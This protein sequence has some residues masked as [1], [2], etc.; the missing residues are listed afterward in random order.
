MS[1][2]LQRLEAALRESLGRAL[3]I[4]ADTRPLETIAQA[5][6]DELGGAGSFLPPKDRMRESIN[7]FRATRRLS[8]VREA[9]LV[10]FG[11]IERFS[12]SP[13]PLI[14]EEKWFLHMLAEVDDFHGDPRAFRDCYRGLLRAYWSY[15][16]ESGTA[17]AHGSVSHR[18]LRNYLKERLESV[19]VQG[20]Q[21]KWVD[22]ISEH[23][24][25]LTEDPVDR[26][27]RA[28]LE[29]DSREFDQAREGLEIHGKSWILRHLVLAQ[30]KAATRMSD[31][32]FLRYVGPLIK[33]LD[34]Y[35]LQKHEGLV[36][37]LDRYAGMQSRPESALLRDATIDAWGSP[38]MKNKD[39][40]WQ[41]VK[42][43]SRAMVLG[44]LNLKLIQQFF[45][46]LAEDRSTDQRRVRF[47]EKYHAQVEEIYFALGPS[48]AN[49]RATD[50][51]DLRKEM[52]SHL[53]WLRGGGAANNAFIMRMGGYVIVEFGLTGN[54]CYIFRGNDLPFR[55]SGEVAADR[56]Q[57]KHDSRH[58]ERL[59]H[60][61]RSYETWE[62]NF[63]DVL[64][65]LG[66]HPSPTGAVA[67]PGTP[68]RAGSGET[69][70]HHDARAGSEPYTWTA[71]SRWTSE[72]GFRIED[73]VRR[74]GSLWVVGPPEHGPHTNR[75]EG[76]GFR[77]AE[78]R[79]AWYRSE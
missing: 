67:G 73:L 65:R 3:D 13:L 8:S 23:R 20:T 69:G 52:G 70:P 76:W 14:E 21:R 58:V 15:D 45:D 9:K 5:L 56:T 68:A 39:A 42:P 62:Q 71:L 48:S 34:G 38:W 10:C 32:E 17:D 53:L 75:L 44:W 41:R 18:R 55:L 4:A 72:H 57:L 43:E 40:A 36:L 26:Y 64:R 77:W 25:L 59:L 6:A 49:S 24:N 31:H 37:L 19:R 79:Q 47:W 51:C 28:I 46:V 2:E 16:P 11:C 29:G 27:G 1:I 78:R 60:I 54:A 30:V 35:L 61:D 12:E 63:A 74:G 33:L 66:V 22:V 7:T 50:V